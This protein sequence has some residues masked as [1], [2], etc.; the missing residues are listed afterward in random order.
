MRVAAP[1]IDE[2]V[3]TLNAVAK[4]EHVGLPEALAQRIAVQ[5]NRNLR[6]AILMLEAAKV[7]GGGHLTADQ[8]VPLADWEE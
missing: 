6:R 3:T 5:S 7:Q 8:V 2:V 4:K 1:S